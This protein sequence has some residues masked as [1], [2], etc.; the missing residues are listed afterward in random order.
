M[1]F[2]RGIL[3]CFGFLGVLLSALFL[4][5]PAS[6]QSGLE[7]ELRNLERAAAGSGPAGQREAL[8]QIASFKELAGDFEGAAR[9]WELAAQA[10]PGFRDYLSMLRGAACFMALGE[11][12]R[13]EAALR[14]VLSG[15]AGGEARL[16]ARFL[17]AQLEGLR[18]GGADSSALISL[19]AEGAFGAYKPR[20]YY[21]LW[22]LTRRDTWL[23]ALRE[24]FPRSPEAVVAGGLAGGLAGT[25]A[26][27]LLFPGREGTGGSAPGPVTV[28]QTGIFSREE[29]ARALLERLRGAGFQAGSLR[30]DRPDGNYT[31]VYVVPGPDINAGIREL[32]AAGFD[33]FPVS[34]P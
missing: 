34:I 14:T 11:W 33:S 3:F 25:A 13:A 23:R 4:G 15:G 7:N 6:A 16:Q 18:S 19:L 17:T 28:L 22:K 26:M 32:R 29:N 2:G 9:A 31:L 5:P 30:Q 24:E 10:E 27:W 8:T 21:S 20:I 1:G 12:E